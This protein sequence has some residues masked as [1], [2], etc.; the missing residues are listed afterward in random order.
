MKRLAAVVGLVS[1]VALAQEAPPPSSSRSRSGSRLGGGEVTSVLSGKSLAGGTVVHGQVGF[2]GLSIALLTSVGENLDAGGRISFL[3]AYEGITRLER[4]P[5]IKLQGVFRL[6]LLDR[7]KFNFGLRF[8]PGIFFYSF[9]YPGWTE[10]GLALPVDLVLG[11]ALAPPLMLNVGVDVPMFV[12]FGPVGGLAVPVLIGAG[13]EYALDRQLALTMN[14]RVG[15]SVPVTGHGYL[16]G[17]DPFD[18]WCRD[19]SGWYPCGGGYYRTSMPAAEALI[20]I[21]YKL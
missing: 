7:E 19:A 18:Y 8:S 21:S 4:T 12:A 20:G 1:M 2:P 3:Y 6:Q 5:G 17:Y 10:T 11:I 13:V 14:L 15:P 9:P 16:F